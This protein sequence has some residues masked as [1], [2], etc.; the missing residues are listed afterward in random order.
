MLSDNLVIT[1][2]ARIDNREQLIGALGLDGRPHEE[3]ADSEL[4]L[5]AYEKWGED[6]PKKLLGD[7]AF[8]LWDRRKRLLFCARDHMGVKPF[9]YHLSNEVF[10][11]A[12]EITAL[13]C[14]PEVPR[15]LNEPR[16]ADMLAHNLGDKTDTFYEEVFRLPHAH[17]MIV[18]RNEVS[19]KPYWSLDPSREVQLRSDEE[20]AEAFYE[21]FEEAVRCR[22]RSAFPLGC[23][24]SGGLDSSSVA[25]VAREL[26]AK[27]GAQRLHTLSAVYKE[28]PL[29]DESD[30]IDLVLAIGGFEPHKVQVEYLSPLRAPSRVLWDADEPSILAALSMPWGLESE[31]GQQGVRVLL[32][33][34]DGDTVVS[35]G[36]EYLIELAYRGR[37]ATLSVEIDALSRELGWSR[38]R[39]LRSMVL[40]PAV[41]DSLL[42]A[43]RALRGRNLQSQTGEVDADLVREDFARRIGLQQRVQASDEAGET[44]GSVGFARRWHYQSLVHGSN[45]YMLEVSA[46]SGAALSIEHR[47]PFFDRR[48][49][50]FCLALPPEQKLS[51]GQQ[52]AVMR[53]ALAGIL[54]DEIRWRKDKGNLTPGLVWSLFMFDRW[55]VEDA[56]LNNPGGIERYADVDRLRQAYV[57]CAYGGAAEDVIAVIQAATLELW[58]RRAGFS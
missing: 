41:P 32:T 12:S 23:E 2:D 24:L 34:Y 55:L 1:A 37:W 47:F 6:C 19:I 26:L 3:I 33:G 10:A 48:L 11:F 7:F 20:Y 57:R 45:Q 4:I 13:L 54:P 31:A 53:R 16:V 22:L 44:R 30:Y 46:K 21:V 42:R 40:E 52:R 39:T 28:A 17:S 43:W 36:V 27:E 50:E 14:V 15:R 29:S 51:R 18:G 38:R 49:V 9:Y 25:C 5:A 56:I 8:A 35:H 58:L